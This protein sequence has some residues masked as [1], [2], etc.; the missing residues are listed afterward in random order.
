MG[1]Q[2]RE[3]VAGMQARPESIPVTVSE[4]STQRLVVLSEVEYVHDV[5]TDMPV[6]VNRVGGEEHCVARGTCFIATHIVGTHREFCLAR[7]ERQRATNHAVT[8]SG[9]ARRL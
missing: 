5:A 9:G 7:I 8:S 3:R 6:S 1:R 4:A 2:G